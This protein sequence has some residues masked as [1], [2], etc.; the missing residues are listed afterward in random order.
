[1]NQAKNVY[2]SETYSDEDYAIQLKEKKNRL[3]DMLKP[4]STEHSA[5]SFDVHTSTP[6]HYRMRAEF[7]I[8]H[9]G[10]ESYH[11]MFDQGTKAKYRV[12]ALPSA[13]KLIN[14]AMI[15]MMREV[16]ADPSLRHKLFQLDYLATTSNELVISMLYHRQLNES[17]HEQ[18][19]QLRNKLKL[20]LGL[21]RFNIIGRAKKQKVCVDEDFVY[22]TLYINGKAYRFKQVENSFTQPNATINVQMIEWVLNK[23]GHDTMDLLELYCGNGNFSLP[24]SQSFRKVLA[25]EISKTSVNAA[26]DNIEANGID[27]LQIARLSSEEFTQAFNQTREFNRLRNID[28]SSYEFSTVLVDPPRA[29]LDAQTLALIQGFDKIVYISCNP[30]TLADNLKAL[31]TTHELEHTAMF[32]QFPF[33]PHIESGVILRRKV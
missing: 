19:N 9:E 28:L 26:L 18:V 1:M 12:D 22:E 13:C 30:T 23:L 14:H 24:L 25:T 15:E 32:D 8:W 7:R 5:L 20:T 3:M 29:G 33:T 21:E 6:K 16:N 27:N 2:A 11:I 10:D 17:W 31:L 4:F